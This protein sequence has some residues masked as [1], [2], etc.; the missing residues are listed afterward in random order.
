MMKNKAIYASDENVKSMGRN[1]FK[2]NALYL[3]HSASYI[4]FNYV[5]CQLYIDI[6]ACLGENTRVAVLVNDELVYDLKITVDEGSR[7]IEIVDSETLHYGTVRLIKLSESQDSSMIRI[8]E[9]VINENGKIY[10]TDN[11]KLKIEFIGD[12]I[13]CGYGVDN[14]NGEEE[15][16]VETENA[17]L[18]YPYITSKEANADFQVVAYSGFGLLTGFSEDGEKIPE[19]ALPQYYEETALLPDGTSYGKWDFSKFSPDII[20]IN[21]GTNDFNYCNTPERT[22]EFYNGYIDFLKTVRSFNPDSELLCTTGIMGNNLTDTIISAVW[23]YAYDYKDEKIHFS[24]L[25]VMDDADGC[26]VN[27]HPSEVTQTKTSRELLRALRKYYDDKF[28]I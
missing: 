5:C 11:T 26:G 25:P 27:H 17:M 6:S 22:D 21:I 2:D 14:R 20:V 18:A 12:S 28:K 9:I 13:A 24:Q 19:K 1:E 16:S 10:P 4:E 3:M 23:N 7:I 8:N 15:S